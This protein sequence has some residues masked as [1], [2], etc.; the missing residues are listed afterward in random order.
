MHEWNKKLG[1]DEK[2]WQS[3]RENW[4]IDLIK[5]PKYVEKVIPAIVSSPEKKKKR[6]IEDNPVRKV[7]DI[8]SFLSIDRGDGYDKPKSCLACMETDWAIA[9]SQT[10]SVSLCGTK[11]VN[12][13]T[14]PQH[15]DMHLYKVT[16]PAWQL[17]GYGNSFTPNAQTLTVLE[18][19]I[20]NTACKLLAYSFYVAYG[21][22]LPSADSFN[23][24]L[25]VWK[26]STWVLATTPPEITGGYYSISNLSGCCETFIPR[27]YTVAGVTHVE[28]WYYNNSMSVP[29]LLVD[30]PNGTR[31]RLR[32]FTY[33]TIEYMG[34]ADSSCFA[35][36][37]LIAEYGTIINVIGIEFPTTAAP[38]SCEPYINY[39]TKVGFKHATV[40]IA[41]PPI[42]IVVTDDCLSSVGCLDGTWTGAPLPCYPVPCYGADLSY[43]VTNVCGSSASHLVG[44]IDCPSCSPTP[45]I[46]CAVSPCD[47]TV[48]SSTK[49]FSLTN[50]KG[51]V[52]WA[53]TGSTGASISGTGLLITTAAACGTLTITA[54]DTD[55]CCGGVY[56]QQVRVTDGGVWVTS[57]PIENFCDISNA[58]CNYNPCNGINDQG[59]YYTCTVITGE[60]KTTYSGYDVCTFPGVPERA[61]GEP[62]GCWSLEAGGKNMVSAPCYT[63][64]IAYP[65]P[66]NPDNPLNTK[67]VHVT[68]IISIQHHEWRCP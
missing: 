13:L 55:A 62:F 46:T 20:E 64:C 66:T 9:A 65:C 47:T 36:T 48:K 5:F 39:R 37:P 28:I 26:G 25:Y 61:C 17:I 34:Y 29:I 22:N 12:L 44:C 68:G 7:I 53:V 16:Y 2:S 54:T 23:N 35:Y 42:S 30:D 8:P 33:T 38:M 67:S 63:P 21:I 41:C 18:I 14:N 6:K 56:T 60:T 58:Y 49:Q 52:T 24:P 45:G 11:R 40:P 3:T 19:Q 32:R 50:A 27:V 4:G 57:A 1:G 15:A 31:V 59:T 10:C 51:T 43:S